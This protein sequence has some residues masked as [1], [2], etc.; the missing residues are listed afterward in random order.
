MQLSNGLS[1]VYQKLE[2]YKSVCVGV[3]IKAGSAN[4]NK[5]N[6]GISHFIEHM[7]FKGTEKRSAKEIALIID[8]I[9][10]E[11]NAYTAKECTCYYTK[12]L[13]E[14]LEVGFDVL[15]DMIQH[16]TFEPE[17][18]ELEKT[19]I[20]DEINMYEDSAEDLVEDILTGITFGDHALSLPI[21]G[22]KKTVS[23]FKRDDLVAYYSDYYVANNAVISIAGEFDET[24]LK[25]LCE[26][27]FGEMPRNERLALD[28]VNPTF[29][30]AF[31]YKYKD[32]EQVQV[33]IDMPGVP[34]DDERS[35]D[36][37]LLSNILGGNNSSMLFQKVREESGLSYSIFSQPSFYDDI[38]TMNISFGVAKEN[39][40]QTLRLVIETI[41]ELKRN[42]LTDEDVEHARAHLKGSFVLGLEGTDNYM[43]LIG[44]LEVFTQKE[45]NFDEM[46]T[47]INN[48]KTETVNALIDLCFEKEK[49]A[50]AI[51]GDVDRALTESLFNMLKEG[52]I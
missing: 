22:S 27:Y 52:I 14:D 3:W 39:L 43:D 24:E 47:K 41:N 11:I 30:S 38:G 31:G 37:M 25:R 29:H 49:I 10:G 46:M 40:E 13:G 28:L 16:S 6:N 23:G 21:L 19:V 4:E 35:Y 50:F 42:R 48:I 12:L 36:L 9:G 15:S 2:G 17:H 1:V 5:S 33:S 51:V 45:K 44:R 26:A 18:I 8:G 7:M 34:Y 32:N 20:L